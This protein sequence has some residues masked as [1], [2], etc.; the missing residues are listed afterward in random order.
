V[1]SASAAVRE[2]SRAPKPAPAQ[3]LPYPNSHYEGLYGGDLDHVVDAVGGT[4]DTETRGRRDEAT[5]R[6]QS[7]VRPG[8]DQSGA[9]AGEDDEGEGELLGR[10]GD[11]YAGDVSHVFDRKRG[12]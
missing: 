10:M 4:P 11:G 7:E 3:T 1:D 6:R 8:T 2:H 9:P 5:R 12:S